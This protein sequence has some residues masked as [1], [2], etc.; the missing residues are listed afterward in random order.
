MRMNSA[1]PFTVVFNVETPAGRCAGV[2]L[3]PILEEEEP[4]L[5]PSVLASLPEAERSFVATLPVGRAVFWV[6]GRLALRAAGA[7]QTSPLPSPITAP[8]LPDDRGAPRLP[9]AVVG[10][11]SHKED[12]AVGLVSTDLGWRV[13]I[14]LEDPRALRRDISSRVLTAEE[15]AALAPLDEPTRRAETLARFA[16]KE[17]IYKALDPFLRR[18]IGFQEVTVRQDAAGAWTA[19]FTP[20]AGEGPFQFEIFA[21]EAPIDPLILFAARARRS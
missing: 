10:S 17:A 4:V 9:P 7:A 18:Y 6:G 2:A 19:V 21:L 5:P 11:I 15:Q 16:I 1:E 20:R 14:D 12:L 8:I 13:G 3:P